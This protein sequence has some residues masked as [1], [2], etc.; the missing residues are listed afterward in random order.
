[1]VVRW[2]RV[3]LP[4]GQIARSRWKEDVMA[5][6]SIRISRNVK[7]LLDGKEHIAEV[8]FYLLLKVGLDV[9]PIASFYGL[10]DKEL[11]R[12]SHQTYY[13]V[14]HHR[15]ADVRAFSVDKIDSVVMMAP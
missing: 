2:A 5:L 4:N 8:H 7:I 9:H 10:P 15:D 11:L 1:K 3:K 12:R 13:T 14:Q 6:N